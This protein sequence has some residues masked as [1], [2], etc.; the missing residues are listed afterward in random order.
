MSNIKRVDIQGTLPFD[1]YEDKKMQG[2]LSYMAGPTTGI[3][4]TWS[5]HAVDWVPN[6]FGG[7]T[8]FHTFNI[9]GEDALSWGWFEE[10]EADVKRLGG[11][12]TTN[13]VVAFCG[14]KKITPEEFEGLKAM[15]RRVRSWRVRSFCP[16]VRS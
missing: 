10:F 11:K 9:K 1:C 12:I 3:N 6:S 2:Y 5:D 4:I 8:A 14:F 15:A 13:K 16:L 7:Q